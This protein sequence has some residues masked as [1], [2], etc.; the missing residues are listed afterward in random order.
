MYITVG[1]ENKKITRDEVFK[2]TSFFMDL[3]VPKKKLKNVCVDVSFEPDDAEKGWIGWSSQGGSVKSY[4]VW[5]RPSIS[6][7]RQITCLAHELVHVKQFIMGDVCPETTTILS[8]ALMVWGSAKDD[9]WDNPMEIEAFGRS[10]G[11]VSRYNI[12]YNKGQGK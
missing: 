2:A 8:N 1:G 10:P 5:I 9:Y 3:L 4:K 6:A 7:Q 12:H 11:L